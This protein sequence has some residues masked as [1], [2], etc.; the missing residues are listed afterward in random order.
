MCPVFLSHLTVAREVWEKIWKEIK[1]KSGKLK[2]LKL[3][4]FSRR[5]IL[6]MAVMNMYLFCREGFCKQKRF[7]IQKEK[8]EKDWKKIQ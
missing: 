4:H 3:F 5:E 6:N 7:L 8:K 1:L 2:E